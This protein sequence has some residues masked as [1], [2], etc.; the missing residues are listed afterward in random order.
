[1]S[2]MQ[3][4]IYDERSIK[5]YYVPRSLYYRNYRPSIT[6]PVLPPPLKTTK[7]KIDKWLIPLRKT[8]MYKLIYI[9]IKYL[10]NNS[11]KPLSV[12]NAL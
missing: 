8:T 1:M 4:R 2:E 11:F 3:G 12:F 9:I 10:M 6:P 7:T 5:M